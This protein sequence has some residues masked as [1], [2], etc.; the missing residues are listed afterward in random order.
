MASFPSMVTGFPADIAR[1]RSIELLENLLSSVSDFNA[2][3]IENLHV[4]IDCLR[5]SSR[6]CLY[7]SH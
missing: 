3:E 4:A 7:A 6:Q 5:Y 2:A 1:S